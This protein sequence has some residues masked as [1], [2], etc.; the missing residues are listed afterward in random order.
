MATIIAT[1]YGSVPEFDAEVDS[2]K[3]YIARAKF[4]FKA[5]SIPEDKQAAIFLSCIGGKT[6]DLLDSL[7]APTPLDESTF[8]VL[9]TTLAGHFH[10][11]PNVISQ[12]FTFNQINQKQDE[13]I[14]EY[15]AALRKLAIDCN[16]ASKDTIEEALRDRLVGGV[17]STSIQKRLLSMKDLTFSDANDTAKAMEAAETHSK[18]ITSGTAKS[19]VLQ[20]TQ[21]SSEA[22]KKTFGNSQRDMHQVQPCYHCGKVNHSSSACRFKHA[23]CHCCGKRGHIATICRSRSKSQQSTFAS[24]PGRYVPSRQTAQPHGNHHAKA[25]YLDV[26]SDQ[27]QEEEELH[28][29]TL[30]GNSRRPK[31]IQF[32]LLF[33]G[34][35]VKMELDTGAEVSLIPEVMYRSLFSHK[36]LLKSSIVLKTY[37]K[38]SIPVAGEINVA[39]EYNTQKVNANLVVV[40]IEGPALLGRDLLKKIKLDW[41]VINQVQ[42]DITLLSLLEEFKGVFENDLGTIKLYHAKLKIRPN[43]VP[44]F[45]K[46]RPLPFAIK[47]N[48]TS[49]L[50]KLEEAGIIEK[51]SHSDWATPIVA[52][53]KRDGSYRIVGIIK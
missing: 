5:N 50:D 48:I 15:L 42:E 7:L 52:V 1:T 33:D 30:S 51:V 49:E 6:Y 8:E 46:P 38:E 16:F 20:V 10:S 18:V 47:D 3:S 29:F 27:T 34:E 14:S 41:A 25:N 9:S 21:Q 44:K 35:P 43:S 37:M 24:K 36:E 19:S 39:V 11:K 40:S 2:V 53:P 23:H 32:E 12:R 4:F 45:F 22:V 26:E 31:P 17:R 28:L 13:S